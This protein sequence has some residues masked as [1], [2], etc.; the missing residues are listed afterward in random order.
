MTRKNFMAIAKIINAHGN[1][2][3]ARVAEAM[4][5]YLRTTN[6]RF[7]TDRFMRA[8]GVNPAGERTK[9]AA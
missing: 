1:D 5:S 3:K 4:A 2:G 7:D 8:C 9:E 6:E